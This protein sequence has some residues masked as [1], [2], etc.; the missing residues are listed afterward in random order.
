MRIAL[1][2]VLVR[3]TNDERS[4]LSLPHAI[5]LSSCPLSRM[6]NCMDLL[7]NRMRTGLQFRGA[8]TCTNVAEPTCS[9]AIPTNCHGGG[10]HSE[11]TM[12]GAPHDTLLVSVTQFCLRSDRICARPHSAGDLHLSMLGRSP[13][14]PLDWP[15]PLDCP[16]LRAPE[17]PYVY[18]GREQMSLSKRM[19]HCR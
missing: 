10:C 9:L 16:R 6:F 4:G 11:P 8:Q 3:T 15:H 2:D 1:A 17:L 7:D 19:F 14:H 5:A 13:S 12:S 18:A